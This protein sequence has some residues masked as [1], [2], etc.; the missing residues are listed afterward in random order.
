M[1]IHYPMTEKVITL[2]LDRE[3]IARL[4]LFYKTPCN[5]RQSMRSNIEAVEQALTVKVNAK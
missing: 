1:N 3:K 2:S 5:E 4:K